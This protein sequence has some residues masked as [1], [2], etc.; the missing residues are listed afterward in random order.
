[1]QVKSR[2]FNHSTREYEDW[3]FDQDRQ[4]AVMRIV[5]KPEYPDPIP[6]K[7]P[8]QIRLVGDECNCKNCK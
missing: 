5:E 1:M 2:S 4:V 7:P 3:Y 8:E 6:L